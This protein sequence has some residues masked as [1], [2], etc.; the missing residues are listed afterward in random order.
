MAGAERCWAGARQWAGDAAC[1]SSRRRASACAMWRRPPAW[2]SA[3]CR[4]PRPR[5]CRPAGPPVT[6]AR[7]LARQRRPRPTRRLAQWRRLLAGE[8][9]AESGARRTQAHPACAGWAAP[10]FRPGASGRPCGPAGPAPHGRQHR[11]RGGR[12]L[13]GLAGA[14]HRAA[15]G[16]L[17]GMLIAAQVVGVD[18]IWLYLRDEYPDVRALLQRRAGPFAGLDGRMGA[19]LPGGA[20][21]ADRTAARCRGLHLRRRVGADRVGRGQARHAPAQTPHRGAPRRV[22]PPHAGAQR[23]TL[24]W[25][26]ELLAAV[27]PGWRSR[28]GAGAAACAASVS[29]GGWRGP[30]CTWRRPASPC[31]S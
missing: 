17:E 9:T 10:V 15:P 13:Q 3:S 7:V 22:W 12:H 5:R 18:R 27:A 23:G 19:A 1:G 14:G 31:R 26:P 21:A 8:I 6:P 20:L 11:R 25:L 28:A 2:G 4:R 29:R 16:L 30:G 24:W